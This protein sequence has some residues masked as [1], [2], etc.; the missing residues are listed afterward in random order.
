[1]KFEP[2][3]EGPANTKHDAFV[4]TIKTDKPLEKIMALDI[5][6]CMSANEP[7]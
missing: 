5:V 3:H 2:R 7:E 1:V 6:W 4:A